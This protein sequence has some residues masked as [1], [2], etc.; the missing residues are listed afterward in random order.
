MLGKEG[1]AESFPEEVILDEDLASWRKRLE[2]QTVKSR[3]G[4]QMYPGSFTIIP[5]GLGGFSYGHV[6]WHLMGI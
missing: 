3:R 4:C 6:S 5:M 2:A 1:L